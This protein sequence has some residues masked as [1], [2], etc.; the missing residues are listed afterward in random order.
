M[1]HV[2]WKGELHTPFCWGNLTER[3]NLEA[4]G[5]DARIIL[6]SILNEYDG[7]A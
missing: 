4:P 7:W 5:V 2:R 1:W 6:K 3:H